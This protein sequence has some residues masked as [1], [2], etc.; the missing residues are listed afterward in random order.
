MSDE[1]DPLIAS[2]ER[3]MNDAEAKAHEYRI[4]LNVLRAEKGL[5]PLP[6]TPGGGPARRDEGGQSAP[7][8]VEIKSDTFFGKKLST[9]MREFLTMR[10]AKGDGPATPREIFDALRL[11]GYAFNTK[12]DDIA[13]VNIRAMLRKNTPTFTRLPGTG[14]YGLTAWYPDA[15]KPRATVVPSGD[16]AD[17]D[18]SDRLEGSADSDDDDKASVA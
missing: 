11:G 8:S 12:N 10:R 5:P 9:A 18:D 2:I 14:R 6:T 13:L 15:R 3:K 4:T 17:D 16:S 7:P 1:I